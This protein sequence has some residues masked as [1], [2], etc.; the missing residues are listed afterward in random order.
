MRKAVFLDRDGVLNRSI[1]I[2]GVP[3]PPINLSQVEILEG[4]F[5][6]IKI[7]KAQDF[8]PIVITN[9]PDVSRRKVSE[10]MVHHIN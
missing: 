9:Q 8:I 2:D 10:R 1:L 3:T 7:F 5:E 6:A 4:V